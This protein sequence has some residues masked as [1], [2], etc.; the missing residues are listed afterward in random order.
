MARMLERPVL[1][2]STVAKGFGRGATL[3]GCPTA[4]MPLDEIGG[5][6]GPVSQLGTGIYACWA[7]ILDSDA[8]KAGWGVVEP[9]QV[10]GAQGLQGGDGVVGTLTL[11]TRKTV[12]PHIMHKF[13]EDFYGCRIKLLVCLSRPEKNFSSMQALIDAIQEDIRNTDKVLDGQEY[14][15]LREHDFFADDAVSDHSNHKPLLGVAAGAL[16]AAYLASK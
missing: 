7:Q 3:L 15:A 16:L 11:T 6:D 9:A 8:A 2:S 10:L 12:E 13:D 4:N 1:L 14:A 5:E